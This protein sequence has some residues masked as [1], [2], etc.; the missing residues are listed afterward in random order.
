M[1]F[2][3]TSTHKSHVEVHMSYYH[4][5]AVSLC[6][7]RTR[8]VLY[9]LYTQVCGSDG[10]TYES[11]CEL[12]GAEGERF[13]YEGEACRRVCAVLHS[14]IHAY[15]HIQLIKILNIHFFRRV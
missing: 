11:I 6:E 8:D 3:L 12:E 2:S 10:E 9:I 5:P 7:H 15:M 1:K 14:S 13:D 4:R